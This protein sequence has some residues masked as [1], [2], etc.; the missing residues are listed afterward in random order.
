MRMDTPRH[1]DPHDPPLAALSPGSPA[2]LLLAREK[3][4]AHSAI[5]LN[6]MSLG[7]GDKRAEGDMGLEPDGLPSPHPG[8][9]PFHN[10]ALIS[11]ATATAAATAGP[12]CPARLRNRRLALPPLRLDP[13]L[14]RRHRRPRRRPQDPR[15]SEAPRESPTG[16]TCVVGGD[17]T[18]TRRSRPRRRQGI[19]PEPPSPTRLGS[20]LRS[21]THPGVCSPRSTASR[22]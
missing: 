1:D 12:N 9:T 14:D 17:P 5:R 3:E 2:N 18:Q 7:C 11:P 20:L 16:R 8:N 13:A 21:A 22:Y 10:M 19:R 6:A 15:M 4:P